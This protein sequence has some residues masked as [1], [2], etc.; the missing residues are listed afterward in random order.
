M[1]KWLAW[2]GLLL[3]FVP[4]ILYADECS[5]IVWDPEGMFGSGKSRIEA[6]AQAFEEKFGANVRMHMVKDFAGYSSFNTYIQHLRDSCD[7]WSDDGSGKLVSLVVSFGKRD[8]GLYYW[9]LWKTELDPYSKHIRDDKVA[10]FLKAGDFSGA[11]T[12]ALDEIAKVLDAP[13]PAVHVPQSN[14]AHETLRVPPPTVIVQKE[15]IDM[16]GLW[17][18][19]KL[20]LFAAV[21][22][23]IGTIVSMFFRNKKREREARSAAQRKAQS[24]KVQCSK[25]INELKLPIA[26]SKS[27]VN[28]LVKVVDADDI[29]V[30]AELF[31]V[32][33]KTYGNA[34]R[35]YAGLPSKMDPNTEN[36]SVP[37]Y[38]TIAKT[39]GEILELL[40]DVRAQSNTIEQQVVQLKKRISE[41]PGRISYVEHIIAGVIAEVD[42]VEQNGYRVVPMRA[43]LE[44]VKD[45]L[46]QAQTALGERRYNDVFTFCDSAETEAGIASLNAAN[47]SELQGNIIS[48]IALTEDDVKKVHEIIALGKETF[49]AVSKEYLASAWMPVR[50]NGTEAENAVIDAMQLLQQASQFSTI[51]EQR[52]EQAQEL[53]DQ[54]K[55]LIA[56][57]QSL[58]HSI[59]E[60]SNN[61]DIAKA[62]AHKEICDAQDDIKR[63]GEYISMYDADIDDSWW[64]ALGNARED[65]EEAKVILQD[66]KPDYVRA[67]Q[68][69][70]SA[71]DSAD[72]ILDR[73]E[74]ERE[75]M[76]RKRRR[77]ANARNV[78][79]RSLSAA[80]E[81]LQDH[82]SDISS[83]ARN[84]IRDARE[85]FD[86]TYMSSS[87][88]LNI[89]EAITRIENVSSIADSALDIAQSDVYD[90]QSSISGGSSSW[91]TSSSSIGGS[92][93]G[94]WGSSSSMSISG[95]SSGSWGS[96]S[97]ISGGSSGGW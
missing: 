15:A 44:N 86:G 35:T 42:A 77:L 57:A 81:Y 90:A 39:Y 25:L 52:W 56:R 70:I 76:V 11:F 60:L 40:A 38:V 6:S 8:I 66:V 16:S 79:E 95:G 68:I 94:S 13:A 88:S 7:V 85:K 67:M 2:V 82:R 63:A 27:L 92:S 1:K 50:G 47:L 53:L 87:D 64:S 37:E 5:S 33:E 78:A 32:A 83:Q 24:M 30:V 21:F 89:S 3:C 14:V 91:G 73:A 55:L 28:S 69:A 29:V 97:G 9:N 36:L 22:A 61:L 71:N 41:A 48:Q 34:A 19:L 46:Q 54:S 31:A 75:V 43:R 72:H 74:D 80:E 84:K 20:F 93:S 17:M 18:V 12:I 49:L 59:T 62:N 4:Q 26:R 58:I 10:P 45:M 51:E 65:L 23:V 96:S